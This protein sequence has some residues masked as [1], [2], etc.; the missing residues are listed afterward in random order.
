[1]KTAL[2]GGFQFYLLRHP[3]SNNEEGCRSNL[4]G[5]TIHCRHH[6]LFYKMAI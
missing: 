5:T 6:L 2:P 4:H 3:L 1:L